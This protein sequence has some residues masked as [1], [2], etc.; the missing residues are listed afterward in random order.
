MCSCE[1]LTRVLRMFI[2]IPT[3]NQDDVNVRVTAGETIQDLVN[4]HLEGLGCIYQAKGHV[5]KLKYT[6]RC[7]N[8]CLWD[9][10]QCCRN[11]MVCPNQIYL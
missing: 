10:L 11:L 3:D 8:G 1:N 4:E 6:E 5:V 9:V 2:C 7:S